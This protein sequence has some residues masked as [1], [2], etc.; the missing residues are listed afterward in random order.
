MTPA[1]GGRCPEAPGDYSSHKP[2]GLGEGQASRHNR[3]GL[4]RHLAIPS[5]MQALGKAGAAA[6][7]A[8]A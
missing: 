1:H 6:A 4:A 8:A 7:A 5:F 2:A 3:T